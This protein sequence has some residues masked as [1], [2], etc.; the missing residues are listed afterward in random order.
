MDSVVYWKKD[1]F[2]QQIN[3]FVSRSEVINEAGGRLV[4]FDSDYNEILT[5]K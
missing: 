5:T 1:S 4:K 3:Q 2:F